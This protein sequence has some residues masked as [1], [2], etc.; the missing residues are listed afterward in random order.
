MRTLGRFTLLLA[1]VGLIAACREGP[2][3]PFDDGL[4]FNHSTNMV[5]FK[6]TVVQLSQPGG[7]PGPASDPGCV[8][9]FLANFPAQ[10]WVPIPTGNGRINSTQT[11]EGTTVG[12]GCIDVKNFPV[13]PR[14]LYSEIVITTANGDEIHYSALNVIDFAS[15]DFV[16]TATITGGT[17]RF[18]GAHGSFGFR[19]VS[20]WRA[21]PVETVIDGVISNRRSGN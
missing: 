16:G 1:T 7:A 2:A 13:G 12:N 8:A 5:P 11:G 15:P 20:D 9:R 18:D 10:I 4:A 21:P 17:G 14:Q 19:A 6:G 3:T